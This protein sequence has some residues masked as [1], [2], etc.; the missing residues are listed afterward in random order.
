MN[1]QTQGCGVVFFLLF[2]ANSNVV[3]FVYMKKPQLFEYYL[4]GAIVQIMDELEIT[5]TY[6]NLYDKLKSII[7]PIK[8][9]PIDWLF[10]LNRYI[11]LKN[12]RFILIVDS[13][14]F[15]FKTNKKT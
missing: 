7:L 13:Q 4:S 12:L 14:S 10:F 2:T 11:Y 9:Q 8:I 6:L 3:K 15:D 1:N 5:N